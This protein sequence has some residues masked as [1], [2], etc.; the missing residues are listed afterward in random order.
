MA[1]NAKFI[2]SQL[3]L[4]SPLLE[5]CSLKTMRMG[6]D[7]VGELAEAMYRKQVLVKEH[8]FEN[9]TGGW[10]IPKDQRRE[11]VILYL[12][13]GGYTCGG[14]DYATGFGSMLAAQ[15]GTRVFC[16]AY[17]LSP[18][19]P[20]P[21]A[22]EDTLTAYRYLLDKGYAPHRISL[23]GES[24]GGGLCYS[25]CL[26]L[27]EEGLP[28][29]G[30]IIAIS[31]WTDLTASGPS[32][33]ENK[34]KDPSIT[35]ERLRFFAESY[36]GDPKD[37]FVSPL[38]GELTGM[39]P[40]LVFVGGDEIMESDAQLMHKKLLD[41][42]CKST[43]VVRPERWHAYILYGLAE[44]SQDFEQINREMSEVQAAMEETMQ[45][46]EDAAWELEKFR[47]DNA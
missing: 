37:P 2:R 39:P 7:K 45:A 30:S 36:G 42:G 13:G 5:N 10:V 47:K 25:L 9:F 21:A 11:G 24:A 28:L 12:H 22:L 15:S 19:N 1:P 16:V 32:Y 29:P 43:L 31:P 38:F 18:E 17:R 20:Y 26:K 46:W 41:S 40:S 33:E 6:Q 34:E 3:S 35:I 8:P 14:L 23:C 27:K 44:D 4:L